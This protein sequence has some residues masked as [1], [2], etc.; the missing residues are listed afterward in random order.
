MDA[1]HTGCYY[2]RFRCPEYVNFTIHFHLVL[3]NS[4]HFTS[5]PLVKNN[6]YSWEQHLLSG[7][8]CTAEYN[9]TYTAIQARPE[10]DDS[11][12]I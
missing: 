7:V 8:Y 4:C 9:G 10:W 12:Q 2:P 11:S 5:M 1:N 6:D 3:K